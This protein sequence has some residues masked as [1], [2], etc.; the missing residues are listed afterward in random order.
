MDNESSDEEYQND[1]V[2]FNTPEDL[3]NFNTN[4]N[5]MK[6]SYIT[7][8]FLNKYEKTRVI[9]ERSQQIANGATPLLKNPESYS[10]VYEIAMEELKQKKI[11]FII[12]RPVSNG[13]EYWKLADL[14]FL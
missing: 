8:P 3:N 5:E 12:K 11:P 2:I 4:Y 9:S 6:K 10:S 13:F 7:S 14:K 1:N